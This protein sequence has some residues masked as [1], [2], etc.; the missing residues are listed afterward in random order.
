M[1]IR[2]PDWPD[3]WQ[4]LGVGAGGEGEGADVGGM[5]VC[6]QFAYYLYIYICYHH[7][8]S[9]VV[10]TSCVSD[11]GV[12]SLE[13]WRIIEATD[14]LRQAVFYYAGAAAAAGISYQGAVICTDDG[15]WPQDPVRGQS[16]H[17]CCFVYHIVVA[18]FTYSL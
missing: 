2:L 12:T 11:N 17:T 6:S 18:G 8:L 9:L 4:G 7:L 5:G 1:C 3:L 16:S 13:F 10:A 14:D 15:V